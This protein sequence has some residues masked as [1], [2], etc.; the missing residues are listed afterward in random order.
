MPSSG[1]A[2]LGTAVNQAEEPGH[3]TQMMHK[4]R[5]LSSEGMSW[6][7]SSG[8]AVTSGCHCG[9]KLKVPGNGHVLGQAVDMPGR[10]SPQRT[11]AYSQAASGGQA[12]LCHFLCDGCKSQGLCDPLFSICMWGRRACESLCGTESSSSACVFSSPPLLPSLSFNSKSYF[13]LHIQWLTNTPVSI[14]CHGKWHISFSTDWPWS[15]ALASASLS[16]SY[17]QAPL[18]L[19]AFFGCFYLMCVS[20]FFL[21]AYLYTMYILGAHWGHHIRLPWDWSNSWLWVTMWVLGSEIWSSASAI[22]VSIH[23]WNPTNSRFNCYL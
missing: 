8:C 11:K 3:P 7:A 18:F 22:L 6:R 5:M 13:F 21:H 10:E 2:V 4:D 19:A 1:L 20:V 12:Q 14:L 15:S 16:L 9:L 17:R 23:L